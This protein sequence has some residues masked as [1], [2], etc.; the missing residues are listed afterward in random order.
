[1]AGGIAAE[2]LPRR[3]RTDDQD[4]FDL[5]RIQRQ[6]VVLILE[7]HDGFLGGPQGQCIVRGIVQH[8]L[9]IGAAR[10]GRR[11]EFSLGDQLGKH[12]FRAGVIQDGL[13]G[14]IQLARLFPGKRSR[15][16]GA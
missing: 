9:I 12:I 1:V 7:Q 16:P 13:L 6:Q 4:I 14:F 11:G 8:C 2:V 10:A 15:A 5:G 3:Q